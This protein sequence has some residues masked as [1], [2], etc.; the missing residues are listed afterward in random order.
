MLKSV[1]VTGLNGRLE[2]K[3]NFQPDL[4]LITGVNGSGKTTLLKLIWYSL[5]GN[6]ER[7][8]SEIDFETVDIV[9]S[10]FK[11]QMKWAKKK[12]RRGIIQINAEGKGH[13]K[14]KKSFPLSRWKSSADSIDQINHLVASCSGKSFFF[15]TFRRIEGGFAIN[16]ER[17]PWD[18]ESDDTVEYSL[19]QYTDLISVYDHRFI[20]S[21]STDDVQQ[22]LT[23]QY[24][25]SVERSNKL[26]LSLSDEIITRIRKHKTGTQTGKSSASQLNRSERVLNDIHR[27]IEKVNA[28]REVIMKPFSV[29]EETFKGVFHHKGIRLTNAIVFGDAGKAVRADQLSAGE[30]Q[31]LSFLT[32]NAFTQNAIFFIDEPEI[33]LHADWQRQ[34]FRLLLKQNTGNQFIAATHSPFIYSKYAEKEHPLALEKGE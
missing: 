33:S 23:R 30:K 8:P 11:I 2:H 6:I 24:A 25:D 20:A 4:N 3:L 29:L 9:G 15:P 19:R 32:Y 10:S 17:E 28:D 34:L 27:R 12:L 7:I 22:L 18:E 1:H 16:P 31:M 14:V 13:K 21:I 26:H 5:S